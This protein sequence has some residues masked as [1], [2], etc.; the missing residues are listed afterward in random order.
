MIL[1]NVT[2]NIEK[3]VEAEW[4]EWMR[5]EHIPAVLAT[6]FFKHNK[7]FRLLN[8]TENNDSTY[9][10]Q[11]FAEGMDQLSTY[12]EDYAPALVKEHMDRY[13]YKHVAF[14][15]VLEEIA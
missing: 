9:S 5:N 14:R 1:Y 3:D 10:I 7:I 2:V 4:L 12:L 11:Y 13:K 6:G 15:T 8:E